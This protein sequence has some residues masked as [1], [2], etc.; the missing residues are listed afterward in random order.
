[1]WATVPDLPD[2][3]HR[4]RGGPP[5]EGVTRDLPDRV[6]ADMACGDVLTMTPMSAAE[7]DYIVVGA[8]TAG[9]VLAARLAEDPDVT[10]L[11]V[12]AGPDGRGVAQ[13]TDPALWETLHHS[14]LD[15]CYQYAPSPNVAGR[16]IPI[17]RGRVLGG[18]GAMNAMVWDRGHPADY[19]EWELAGAEGWNHVSLLPYFRRAEDWEGGATD[20]RGTGGPLHVGQP[21]HPHPLALALLD[22]AAELGLPRADDAG[23]GAGREGAALTSMNI[24]ARRRHSVADGYLGRRPGNLTIL[25]NSTAIRLGFQ[26]QRCVSLLHSTHGAPRETHARR[27]VILALGTFGTPQ[28]LMS[29]GIG[30]PAELS[31]LGIATPTALPGVGRNLQDHPLL[32]GMNFRARNRLGLV[33]DNGSGAVLNWRSSLADRPDLQA[34]FVQRR[35]AD[36]A[37]S[38]RYGLTGDASVFAISPALMRPRSTGYLRMH[39]SGETEIQANLLADP[40]DVRALT[41]SM[42]MIAALA[43]SKAYRDLIEGPVMPTALSHQGKVRFVREHCSTYF[44]PCGTA[45]IGSVVD[46][47]LKVVGVNGLR[48]AD[49]SV[50]PVI[51]GCGTQA[52]VVAIAERAADLIRHARTQTRLSAGNL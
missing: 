2:I 30:D 13:I 25:T 50:I 31:R 16:A 44:H 14:S 51:P 19:D 27:E 41:E 29:S 47:E 33:R 45:A 39:P 52:P 12:E 6:A 3:W 48:V 35:H 17:P 22:A 36:A 34:S 40:Q 38:A 49:A 24:A 4:P 26:A 20:Y 1:M 32:A 43:S 18:C 28:L 46:P 37:G 7:Y 21:K 5:G 15:W 8:G 10:V 9:C 23:S 11:L 42:D